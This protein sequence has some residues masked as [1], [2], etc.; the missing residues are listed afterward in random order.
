MVKFTELNEP[1]PTLLTAATLKVYMLNSSSSVNVYEM[2]E[3][4]KL[5]ST[6]DILNCSSVRIRLYDSIPQDDG[7][8]Q[9]A[10]A[11]DAPMSNA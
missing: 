1:T 11:D 4:F 9:A 10:V 7:A 6:G 8:S 3:L 2:M 5:I